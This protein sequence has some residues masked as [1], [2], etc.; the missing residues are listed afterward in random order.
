LK[1]GLFTKVEGQTKPS[2]VV[3]LG[4]LLVIILPGIAQG[5]SV[6]KVKRGD[7]IYEL[8][9]KYGVS[10]HSIKSC[11]KLTKNLIRVGQKLVIPTSKVFKS[12]DKRK[13]TTKHVST[14]RT[15]LRFIKHSVITGESLSEIAEDFSVTVKGLIKANNLKTHTI[16]VGQKLVI[17]KFVKIAEPQR[18]EVKENYLI[19]S[20]IKNFARITKKEFMLLA[21]IINAESGGENYQGQVAVGAV[22]LNRL[23]SGAFPKSIRGIVYERTPRGV[24][25]FSPV[26]NGAIHREPTVAAMKAAEEA[27]QGEDPTKGALY[28]YNPRK[29]NDKWIRTRK[30]ITKIGNHVFAK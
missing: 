16:K 29:S 27:L 28:F 18:G 25:Q 20:G 23:E 7:T 22:I 1:G 10:V 5:G 8:S 3:I 13:I 14:R 30:P 2:L 11:N 24:Y 15:K 17:P 4:L 21:K 26:G 19:A 12:N 9:I 6:H